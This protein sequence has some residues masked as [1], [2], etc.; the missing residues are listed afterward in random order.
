[1]NTTCLFSHKCSA[2]NHVY[3]HLLGRALKPC[4]VELLIDPFRPGD[5]TDTRMDSFEFDSLLL[6]W[7]PESQA[8]AA[9]QRELRTALRRSAPLFVAVDPGSPIRSFRKRILWVRPA[10]QSPE[11]TAKV[12]DL[13]AAIVARVA[14]LRNLRV[15]RDD[16]P[17][18]DSREAAQRLALDFETTLL[19]EGGPALARHFLRTTDEITGSG[20]GPTTK[21][22]VTGLPSPSAPRVPLR[23]PEC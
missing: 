9:V 2:E 10:E 12:S 21:L 16:V 20:S 15:L 5:R 23:R 13:A 14:F 17:A 1:V 22:L 11:F 8:S 18:D 19:A 3:G 7:S 6:L 4:D